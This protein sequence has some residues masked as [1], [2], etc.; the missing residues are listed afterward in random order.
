MFNKIVLASNNEGK[1]KEFRTFFEPYKIH[2]ISQAELDVPEC[3][4]PFPTFIENALAKARHASRMT[5]LPALSDDSGICATALKG[6]PG[7]HS[8]RFAGEPRSDESN[9][10]K[11]VDALENFADKQV[12]YVCALALVRSEL[13]PQPIIADGIWEGHFLDQPR[14]ENGF[15][16]D[17]HFLLPEYRL[18]AAEIPSTLKTRISHRGRALTIL[19]EKLDELYERAGL[20]VPE[21]P[22]HALFTDDTVS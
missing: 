18:T 15:G 19:M 16:Y 9:N 8:A 12:W 1:L 11:L 17:A 5:G 7:I 3:A 10:L 4:E 13:D 14:G 2:I 6:A 22:F 20:A 21:E